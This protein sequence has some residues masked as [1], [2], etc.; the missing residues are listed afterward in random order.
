MGLTYYNAGPFCLFRNERLLRAIGRDIAAAD[1]AHPG[2]WEDVLA[3]A[4]RL[5][6]DGASPHPLLLRWHDDPT[7]MTWAFLAECFAEG[8]RLVDDAL[9]A[10]FGP[11]TGAARVIAR[12]QR[13]WRDRLVPPGILGWPAS[14]FDAAWMAGGHA[15]YPSMDYLLSVYADH[16]SSRIRGEVGINPVMPG[17][18]H[19]TLLLGHALLCLSGR[20]RDAAALDAAWLLLRFLGHRD[21]AG[22]LFVHRRWVETLNLWVPFPEI[23]RDPAIRERMR[24]WQH[25][26]VA[27]A[28]LGWQLAGRARALRPMIVTAP[29][30]MDWCAALRRIVRA[31]LLAG[32]TAP[33]PVLRAVRD[34]WERLAGRP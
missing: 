30:Y 28:A 19:D 20:Q 16:P 32:G 23:Y 8:D 3:D 15:Y 26:A 11:D 24:G 17:T 1:S 34:A 9:R 12:W 31:D 25:P 6:R 22:Q 4:D 18:T 21:A 7:G 2:R 10:S 14:A 13:V 5:R 29:W 27:E 33:E